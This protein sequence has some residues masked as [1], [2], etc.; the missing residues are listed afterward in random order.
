[1]T[2]K[3]KLSSLLEIAPDQAGRV[4][5]GLQ[6]L[7]EGQ[8]GRR[9]TYKEITRVVAAALDEP[10]APQPQGE[11]RTIT[12]KT[13]L[14]GT[15]R[16]EPVRRVPEPGRPPS[17]PLVVISG[18]GSRK[19]GARRPCG[20]CGL[21]RSTL[22]RYAESNRGAVEI[23]NV[24]KPGVLDRSWGRVDASNVSVDARLLQHD[25]RDGKREGF[26]RT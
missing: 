14:N 9:P 6:A 3:K 18:R 10:P 11:R 15:A 22:W 2:A 16:S 8:N 4:L 13:Y 20:N 19:W 23:C 17:G 26:R 21:L 12:R 5:A 25:H 7:C 24:C 1:M